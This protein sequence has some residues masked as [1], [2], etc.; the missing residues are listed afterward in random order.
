MDSTVL[1]QSSNIHIYSV[2][3][4]NGLKFTYKETKPVKKLMALLV[5]RKVT[6]YKIWNHS[7]IIEI[8]TM[9]TMYG[10]QMKCKLRELSGLS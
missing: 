9:L 4:K 2:I 8:V 7:K 1:R 5:R 6:F 10:K 3:H